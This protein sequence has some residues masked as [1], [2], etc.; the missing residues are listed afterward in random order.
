VKESK[1]GQKGHNRKWRSECEGKQHW[2]ESPQL[3]CSIATCSGCIRTS[4]ASQTITLFLNLA[5]GLMK[6]GPAPLRTARLKNTC[7]FAHLLEQAVG[8]L[9]G[10]ESAGSG[11]RRRGESPHRIGT[12]A[13]PTVVLEERGAGR[14]RVKERGVDF[15]P[16][17]RTLAGINLSCSI[18]SLLLMRNHLHT[19]S[20]GRF[21]QTGVP[22][23]R[24]LL[25]VA[26]C[27]VV[28]SKLQTRYGTKAGPLISA[29]TPEGRIAFLFVS[30]VRGVLHLT[31]QLM[32]F[33]S[34]RSLRF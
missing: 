30:P 25:N 2:L 8:K 19:H 27:Y 34:I 11:A 14:V 16:T 4:A 20:N 17:A 10:C 13:P 21:R 18:P 33:A 24:F 1:R 7:R 32:S 3:T 5:V 22:S 29:F 12:S 23:S 26:L 6:G 31:D 28:M 9:Y 15:D